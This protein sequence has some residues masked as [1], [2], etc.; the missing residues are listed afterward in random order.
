MLV[1]CPFL[2][3]MLLFGLYGLISAVVAIWPL[4][5]FRYGGQI[6]V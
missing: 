6:I 3:T 5:A 1:S 2:S 4:A